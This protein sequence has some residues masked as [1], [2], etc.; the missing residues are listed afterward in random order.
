[1]PTEAVAAAPGRRPVALVTPERVL[2]GLLIVELVWFSLAGTNF[3]TVDNGLEI[4][5]AS[6]EVGLLA[7]ALTPVILTG[8]IDLSCGAL[9]GLCAVVFGAIWRDAGQPIPVAAA[10][11]IGV[12]LLGGG[13]NAWMVAGF[14]R[15]ALIVTLGTASLFRGLAEGLTG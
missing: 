7:L 15:P 6:A 8:G 14:G 12:G 5:R 4:L 1:M 2:L 3:L 9:L 13:I 10:G 11:A